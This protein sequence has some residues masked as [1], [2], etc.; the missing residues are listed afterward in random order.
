[1]RVWI[2][3]D[4]HLGSPY[5]LV[6]RLNRFLD[7]LPPDATLVLNGDTV[8]CARRALP[9]SHQL[10]LGRLAAESFRRRVVWI[11]GNH[12]DDYRLPGDH[13]IEYAAS[14]SLGKRLFA[15]HGFDFDNV[16]PHHKLFIRLFRFMHNVRI[17]LGAEGVHVAYYAKKWKPLYAF[18][19]RKVTANA[20]EH[21][22][23]NG[24]G[25][26]V[27]GHTHYADERLVDGI[28]F[29]NTGS[30]TEEPVCYVDADDEGIELRRF[31]TPAP[32]ARS[33]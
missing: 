8:D 24:Y 13:R 27:C 3:S 5:L 12:D 15:A 28:R 25:T 16:M 29:L 31:S 7:S 26:V 6:D 23:E 2:I 14:F 33:G 11:A 9:P 30:W 22:R 18:L 20:V 32:A 19:I 17:R 4:I 21:A 10:L 1:M